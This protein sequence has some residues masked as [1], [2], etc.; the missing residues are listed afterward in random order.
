MRALLRRHPGYVH[1]FIHALTVGGASREALA[2][3]GGVL[4]AALA[5]PA[6]VEHA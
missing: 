6:L 1:G 4:R 2:E 5:T 3:M